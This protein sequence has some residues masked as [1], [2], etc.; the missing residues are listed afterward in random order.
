MNK[1]DKSINYVTVLDYSKGNVYVWN[2]LD[3]KPEELEREVQIA[4]E[5]Q[6]INFNNCYWMQTNYINIEF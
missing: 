6:D 4:C 5:Q 3:I 1:N 2:M